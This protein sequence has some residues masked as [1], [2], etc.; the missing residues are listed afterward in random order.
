MDV[1]V[2]R[3]GRQ[4]SEFSETLRF[5]LL[6]LHTPTVLRSRDGTLHGG[7]KVNAMVQSRSVFVF[8]RSKGAVLVH[9][10]RRHR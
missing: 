3:E 6:T 9:H 7:L 2:R 1:A 10:Q 8:P 4:N 5:G